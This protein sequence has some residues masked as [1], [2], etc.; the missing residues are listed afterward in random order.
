MG[1]IGCHAGHH[2]MSDKVRAILYINMLYISQLLYISQ[3]SY[4]FPIV[5]KDVMW[6]CIW[7]S[8]KQ[9]LFVYN[10]LYIH[11]TQ[12]FYRLIKYD[13]SLFNREDL[14]SARPRSGFNR[15]CQSVTM[16]LPGR[17]QDVPG[18]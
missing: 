9:S 2:G 18:W 3:T 13:N 5:T 7:I 16:D 12:P 14:G 15:L 10:K 11:S 1:E 4:H 8:D 17:Q 6:A